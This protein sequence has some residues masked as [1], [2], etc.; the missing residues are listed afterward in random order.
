MLFSKEA[1]SC[2]DIEYLGR[3]DFRASLFEAPRC[4]HQLSGRRGRQLRQFRRVGVGQAQHLV[5]EVLAVVVIQRR[6]LRKLQSS[7]L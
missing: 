3:Q 5:A 1:G 6:R 4:I 7:A 2:E